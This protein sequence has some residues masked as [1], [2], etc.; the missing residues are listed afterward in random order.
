MFSVGSGCLLRRQYRYLRMVLPSQ[1]RCF[2]TD[3][4]LIYLLERDKW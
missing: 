4:F 2:V 3:L 1:K